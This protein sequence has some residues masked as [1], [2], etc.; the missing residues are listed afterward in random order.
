M[1]GECQSAAESIVRVYI[2]EVEDGADGEGVSLE[3]GELSQYD[4][5]GDV[6][7]SASNTVSLGAFLEFGEMVGQAEVNDLYILNR[8]VILRLV[9]AL[10]WRGRGGRGAV[11]GDGGCG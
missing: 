11:G 3:G 9:I 7:G 10:W 4:L 8:L 6:V 2:Q 5:G 1:I